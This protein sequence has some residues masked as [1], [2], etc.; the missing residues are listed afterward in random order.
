M[1]NN[2]T[3]LNGDRVFRRKS[4]ELAKKNNIYLPMHRKRV[5][6]AGLTLTG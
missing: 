6:L 4:V 3:V 1:Y 5:F 2:M